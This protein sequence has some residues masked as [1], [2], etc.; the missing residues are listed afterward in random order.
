M[1]SQHSLPVKLYRTP[2]RLVVAAPMAG[3]QPEDIRVDVTADGQLILEGGLRG[4]LREEWFEV[5]PAH[6]VNA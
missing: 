2:D 3:L 4:V 1:E 6:V 5:R